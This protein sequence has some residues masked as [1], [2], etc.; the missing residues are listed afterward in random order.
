MPGFGVLSYRPPEHLLVYVQTWALVT[1]SK[2][3]RVSSVWKYR[4][5]HTL[6]IE[7]CIKED[8]RFKHFYNILY[9]QVIL[10]Q[11]LDKFVICDKKYFIDLSLSIVSSSITRVSAAHER[12]TGRVPNILNQL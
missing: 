12:R 8:K 4:R 1:K 9:P 6:E 10:K 7:M 5:I 3:F 2:Y 11:S